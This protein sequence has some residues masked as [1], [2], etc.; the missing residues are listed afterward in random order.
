[1][2]N[3]L[4]DR[5]PISIELDAR[6]I[7]EI[8]YRRLLTKSPPAEQDLAARFKRHGQAAINFTRLTGTSLFKSDPDVDTFK[9]PTKSFLTPPCEN[10]ASTSNRFSWLIAYDLMR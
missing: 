6:Y 4:R 9:Y 2:L 5:F 3:K 10:T 8:T 1:M 7:R